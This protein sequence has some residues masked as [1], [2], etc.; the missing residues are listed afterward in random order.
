VLRIEN[1]ID[2]HRHFGPDSIGGARPPGAHDAFSAVE[3]AREAHA[4]GHKAIVLKSHSFASPQLAANLH[5]LVPGLQVFGSGPALRRGL[6]SLAPAAD[7]ADRRARQQPDQ[8]AEA[9][10]LRRAGRGLMSVGKP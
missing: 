4:S 5:Q 6:P 10:A 7:P 2:M 3:A 9:A 8:A 1:A